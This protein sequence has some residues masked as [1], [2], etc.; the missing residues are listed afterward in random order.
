MKF[1][2]A[3]WIFWCFVWRSRKLL[4]AIEKFSH[5][6]LLT[7]QQFVKCRRKNQSLANVWQ[8]IAKNEFQFEFNLY[9]LDNVRYSAEL[10]VEVCG[11]NFFANR[12]TRRKE[13]RKKD[14]CVFMWWRLRNIVLHHPKGDTQLSKKKQNGLRQKIRQTRKWIKVFLQVISWRESC[15]QIANFWCGEPAE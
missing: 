4:L 9:R 1:H 11:R 15:P 13:E 3:L 14:F 8:E 10:N 5:N 12:E 7:L 2:R 6:E